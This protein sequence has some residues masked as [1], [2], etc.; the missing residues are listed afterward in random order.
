[1]APDRDLCLTFSN[2]PATPY[3]VY[4]CSGGTVRRFDHRDG[5]EVTGGGWPW[6]ASGDVWLHQSKDDARF[7]VLRSASGT[8]VAYEPATTTQKTRVDSNIDEPRMERDGRYVGLGMTTPNNGLNVW[9]WNTNSVIWTYDPLTSATGAPFAHGAQLR[10]LFVQSNW[11]IAIPYKYTTIDPAVAASDTDLTGGSTSDTL[12]GSGNWIQSVARDDQWC[13]FGRY[14]NPIDP[15]ASYVGRG[16]IV[17]V[18]PSGG[19][20]LLAHMYNDTTVYERFPFPKL[21]PDGRYVLFTSNMNGQSRCD[22]FLAKVPT[23]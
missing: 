15:G 13:T 4:I 16:G 7:C 11:N 12:H 14:L 19:R 6:S 3:Y 10:S 21:A 17:F 5:S 8:M 23:S 2:N 20:R 9:D 1:M 22:Q 18:R